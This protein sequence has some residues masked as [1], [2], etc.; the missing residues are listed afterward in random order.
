MDANKIY[1]RGI[2]VLLFLAG[3]ASADDLH[4]K[5][6]KNVATPTDGNDA[7]NKDYVDAA[8]A[9]DPN[10][11][12]FLKLDGSNADQ[13]IDVNGWDFLAEDI[14]ITTPSDIYLLSHDSFADFVAAEHY[15]WTN[16]THA[17]LTTNSLKGSKLILSIGSEIE[18]DGSGW[19]QFS[20]DGTLDGG[21][22]I[23]IPQSAGSHFYYGYGGDEVH[24]FGKDV[25]NRTSI[26]SSTGSII[27]TGSIT[28]NNL[29]TIS[30]IGIATDVDVIQLSAN[31]AA[32]TGALTVS[33]L[34]F[35][36]SD[37]IGIIGDA[38][39]LQLAANALT[40]NATLTA[41][42]GI[43]TKRATDNVSDPPTDAELDMAFGAPATVGAGFVGVLDDNDGGTDVYIVF[44]TGTDAEW[45]YVKGTKAL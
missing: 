19:T 34:S 21:L 37:Q 31:A 15:D 7:A 1:I 16:E 13:N 14:N 43:K 10:Y 8:I 9:G 17:L 6:L 24:Y 11:D 18:D 22:G 35:N 39:L 26:D 23:A 44:T 4:G 29:I 12:L 33:S 28:G 2:L 3:P 5:R 25:S 36:A 42:G 45:F 41:T 27:S 32:I 40:V 38:D 20:G 30:N